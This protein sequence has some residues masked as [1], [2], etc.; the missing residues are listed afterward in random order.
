MKILLILFIIVAVHEAGHLIVARICKIP[1][2]KC[3]IFFNPYFTVFQFRTSRTHYGLGW[4]PLGGFT[5]FKELNT[6]L[7]KRALIYSAGIL[8]NL[9]FGFAILGL[10]SFRMIGE[11]LYCLTHLEI[12][13]LYQYSFIDLAA[14]FSLLIGFVNL[15][16]LGS[17][18]GRK[19][20]DSL[21]QFYNLRYIYKKYERHKQQLKK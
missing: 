19:I 4:L 3:F 18:D 15:I 9:L 12:I 7:L 10:D 21:F 6:P 17:L 2:E 16:P 20:Y 13:T 14:F 11:Y 1:V 8:A 5:K